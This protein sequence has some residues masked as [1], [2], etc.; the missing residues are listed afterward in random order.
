MLCDILVRALPYEITV[1][2]H[3]QV[4]NSSA[5]DKADGSAPSTSRSENAQSD[6]VTELNGMLRFL[7]VEVES[8]ERAGLFDTQGRIESKVKSIQ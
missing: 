2:Y 8:R 4:S 6:S 3:G 1:K 7:R 5:P